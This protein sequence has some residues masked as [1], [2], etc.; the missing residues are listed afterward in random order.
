MKIRYGFTLIE[1]MIVIAVIS[2]LAAVA[3]PTYRAYI[4]HSYGSSAM[5][6]ASSYVSL[7]QTCI[8][9]GKGCT[10]LNLSIENNS[11]LSSSGATAALNTGFTLSFDNGECQI[12]S[13]LEPNGDL[14]YTAIATG[15]AADLSECE[16]GAG[17]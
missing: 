4:A 10:S 11:E 16:G 5:W 12:N 15:Y 9:T 8:Q 6:S 1:L 3:I 2:I 13:I 7:A 14:T 17:I